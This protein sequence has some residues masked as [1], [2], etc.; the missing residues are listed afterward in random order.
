VDLASLCLQYE[1]YTL[2]K[3]ILGV[4]IHYI[5]SSYRLYIQR[6]VT[7]VMTGALDDA[8][9]DFVTAGN[10]APDKSLPYFAL[11]WVLVQSGQTDKA[12]RIL[13]EKSRLQGVDFLVPYI[14]G[15]ALI[16]S[17]AEPGTP[18]AEEAAQA[19]ESSIRMNPNFSHSRAEWGKLLYKRGDTDR[20]IVELKAATSLDPKDAGPLYVLAQAYRKQGKKA[21]ADELLAQIAK[22][23][24]QDDNVVQK[25]E[26]Q[27]LVRQEPTTS[28]RTQANP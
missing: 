4:G 23:H 7:F 11:G 9:K 13:R 19:F 3:E 15:V 26:F 28:S 25:M 1:D 2:G 27:R 12:V 16:H 8:E 24:A 18:A 14:F 10:L 6:G 20:A 5:P 22:L 17:G 21:A